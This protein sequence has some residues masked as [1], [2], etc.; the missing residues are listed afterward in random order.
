MNIQ[1]FGAQNNTKAYAG[2]DTV[3]ASTALPGQGSVGRFV[4]EGPDNCYIS[5]G[6]GTQVATV[7]STSTAVATCTPVEAG[8]DIVLSIPSNAIQNISV[9]CRS[10]K[11][12]TLLVSIGEGM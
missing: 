2:T 5:V 1:P 10:G 7:P 12:A 3:G 9:I 11:T 4:N 8:E 6:I